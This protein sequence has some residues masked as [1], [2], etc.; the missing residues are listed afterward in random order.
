MAEV[1]APLEDPV[2]R[3]APSLG[4][5]KKSIVTVAVLRVGREAQG[6]TQPL[7]WF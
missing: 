1:T 5:R 4:Q 6:L 2:G 3:E 7:C